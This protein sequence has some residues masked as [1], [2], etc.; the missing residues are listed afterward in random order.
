M[1]YF[2]SMLAS[3]LAVFFVILLVTPATNGKP[4]EPACFL[5]QLLVVT[6]EMSVLA[7]N[8]SME[9]IV[10]SAEKACDVL[11]EEGSTIVEKCHVWI[12]TYLEQIID[13]IVVQ[14]FQP[15]DV[16]TSLNLCP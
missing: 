11:G 13:M 1:R 8:V 15:Y 10:H 5:C 6:V 7:N 16:C 3:S 9:Y 12:E 2:L 14:F 4:Q